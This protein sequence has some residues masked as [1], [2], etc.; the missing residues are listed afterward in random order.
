MTERAARMM[1]RAT[2]SCCPRDDY[3]MFEKKENETEWPCGFQEMHVAEACKNHHWGRHCSHLDVWAQIEED[4]TLLHPL[5]P[6]KARLSQY[7]I[8]NV[9]KFFAQ[10]LTQPVEMRRWREY[11]KAATISEEHLS[12]VN[13][14][15]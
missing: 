7:D 4:E 10:T 13:H 15:N 14:H 5:H 8:G 12:Y 9:S 11:G 2:R 6:K 1:H 3:Q